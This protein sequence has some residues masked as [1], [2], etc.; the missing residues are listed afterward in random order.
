VLAVERFL[1]G[2]HR[3]RVAAKRLSPRMRMVHGLRARALM[4]MM[5]T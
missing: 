4:P 1:G 5:A 2:R 3:V